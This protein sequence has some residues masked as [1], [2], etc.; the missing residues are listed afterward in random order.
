MNT[1][2]CPPTNSTV[3]CEPG[4]LAICRVEPD[5]TIH[6]TCYTPRSRNRTAVLNWALA[7]VTGEPR[8]PEQDLTT[9]DRRILE[10][11]RYRSPLGMLVSFSLPTEDGDGAVGR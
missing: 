5:G 1:C 3:T 9:A 7:L 4:Q 8:H 6:S 10:A 2:G 11:G